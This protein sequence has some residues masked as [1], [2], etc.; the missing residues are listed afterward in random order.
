MAR[1]EA[2]GCKGLSSAMSQHLAQGPEHGGGGHSRSG[3]GLMGWFLQLGREGLRQKPCLCRLLAR[4][5]APGSACTTCSSVPAETFL[6]PG[7]P[8]G[9]QVGVQHPAWPGLSPGEWGWEDTG[10]EEGGSPCPP[11]GMSGPWAESS[12][13]VHRPPGCWLWRQLTGGAQ[14]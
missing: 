12:T 14:E 1:S 11:V 9:L 2:V 13:R 5:K 3:F 4:G 6:V 8:R 10:L 7:H